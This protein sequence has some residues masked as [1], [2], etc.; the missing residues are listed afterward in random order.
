M[1]RKIG[2]APLKDC[3]FYNGAKRTIAEIREMIGQG[4]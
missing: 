3:Y 1:K 4:R 2:K